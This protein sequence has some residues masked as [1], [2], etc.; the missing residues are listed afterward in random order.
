MGD[1]RKCL[2]LERREGFEMDA[3]KIKFAFIEHKFSV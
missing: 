1:W 2:T 3:T